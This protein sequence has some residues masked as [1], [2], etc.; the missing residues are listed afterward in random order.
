MAA[1]RTPQDSTEGRLGAMSSSMT[2][3]ELFGI[4][5]A[6]LVDLG[7]YALR[8]QEVLSP[9]LVASPQ[10]SLYRQ[11]AQMLDILT[12]RLQGLQTFMEHLRLALPDGW[13]IDPGRAARAV[14]VGALAERLSG[15]KEPTA[16]TASGELELF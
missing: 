4:I 9:A 11:E 16:A 15:V 2:M 6:E 12:Q 3:N 8:M 13:S 1:Y 7:A 10:S 5:E 14:V